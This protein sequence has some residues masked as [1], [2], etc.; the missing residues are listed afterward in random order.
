MLTTAP[1]DRVGVILVIEDH[2]ALPGHITLGIRVII[3]DFFGPIC[4]DYHP[5]ITRYERTRQPG[6]ANL[7]TLHNGPKS[8]EWAA[9]SQTVTA[10]ICERARKCS[11]SER[12]PSPMALPLIIDLRPNK[13]ACKQGSWQVFPGRD[14]SV[15]VRSAC[16]SEA[17]GL[18]R[19]R[20]WPGL[21]VQRLAFLGDRAVAV[22]VGV[23]VPPASVGA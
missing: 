1:K 11:W 13:H 2:R 15:R 3:A 8:G 7:A 12:Q 19:L 22:R 9:L 5:Y 20:Q 4:G 16:V 23:P 14:S 6:P 17:P 18:S 21:G 10:V